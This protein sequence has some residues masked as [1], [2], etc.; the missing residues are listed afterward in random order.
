MTLK[1]SYAGT[2]VDPNQKFWYIP[3]NENADI[4]I[5]STLEEKNGNN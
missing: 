3:I 1:I 5:T 4:E 2:L